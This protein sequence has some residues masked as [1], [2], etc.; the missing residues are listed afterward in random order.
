MFY[1]FFLSFHRFSQNRC[2]KINVSSCCCITWLETV[3]V[4][5]YFS[6]MILACFTK[7]IF[8]EII[9]S[10]RALS[11]SLASPLVSIVCSAMGKN[12]FKFFWN[13]PPVLKALLFHKCHWKPHEQNFL[14]QH[15]SILCLGILWGKD[16]PSGIRWSTSNHFLRA[17]HPGRLGVI[18]K[19]P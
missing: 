13:A 5:S 1:F 16:S 4:F 7:T 6:I 8:P 9:L 15:H 11:S 19:T 18:I 12:F 3:R 17:R 14:S 10:Y 2:D